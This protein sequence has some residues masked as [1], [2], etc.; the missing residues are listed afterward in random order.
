MT[1]ISS[2]LKV[3]KYPE[4][5]TVIICSDRD[6]ADLLDD[7]LASKDIEDVTFRF[8]SIGVEIFAPS[9]S[10]KDAEKLVIDF[11]KKSNE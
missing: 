7:Y 2:T 1:I 8:S 6:E 11:T 10:M 5:G 3:E 4:F 9:L